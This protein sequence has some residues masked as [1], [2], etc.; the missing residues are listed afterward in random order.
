M[1]TYELE[2]LARDRQQEL[3]DDARPSGFNLVEWIAARLRAR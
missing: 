2:I 1:N 3:L